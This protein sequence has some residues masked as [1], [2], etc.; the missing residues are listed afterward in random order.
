LREKIGQQFVGTLFNRIIWRK[1][2]KAFSNLRFESGLQILQT[3]AGDLGQIAG[4]DECFP[5]EAREHHAH[6]LLTGGVDGGPGWQRG[7]GIQ[8]IDPSVFGVGLK[9][10]FGAFGQG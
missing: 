4:I 9:Q 10:S 2:T 1:F 3:A 5:A 6:Q 7:D 8:V